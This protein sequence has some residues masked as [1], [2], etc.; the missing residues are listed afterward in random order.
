MAPSAS[1]S[2]RCE[3]FTRLASNKPITHLARALASTD[4]WVLT[5][6]HTRSVGELYL[7][8]NRKEFMEITDD[9]EWETRIKRWLNAG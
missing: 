1:A 8:I 7:L 2:R 3:G 4:P 9:R 6:L 5:T